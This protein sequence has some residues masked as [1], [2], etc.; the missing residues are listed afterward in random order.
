VPGWRQWLGAA[1][2]RRAA[3]A[4]VLSS[5]GGADLE[6]NTRNTGN[7]NN[8][9]N[10]SN[11]GS[12]YGVLSG[13]GKYSTLKKWLNRRAIMTQKLEAVGQQRSLVFPSSRLDFLNFDL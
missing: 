11:T 13:N 10:T 9:V 3:A 12:I 5:R 2:P 4:V 8:T 1:A 7:S 6:K